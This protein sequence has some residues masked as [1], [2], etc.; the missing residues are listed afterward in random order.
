MVP[1]RVLETSGST[2]T[3]VQI[4]LHGE[5][6]QTHCA[7]AGFSGCPMDT[8]CLIRQWPCCGVTWPSSEQAC[9]MVND[10]LAQFPQGIPC[11][12]A[13]KAQLH[14]SRTALRC[15]RNLQSALCTIGWSMLLIT[16]FHHS[17]STATD[18]CL[19]HH[20]KRPKTT[21]KSTCCLSSAAPAAHL[22]STSQ[23]SLKRRH[24]AHAG[25]LTT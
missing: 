16:T 9:L 23:L 14:K 12:R 19:Q 25:L 4:S 22:Q 10:T 15:K 13:C 24:H 20:H 1:D 17:A 11:L 8:I 18:T 5:A 2:S 3:C 6:N 21:D 7:V